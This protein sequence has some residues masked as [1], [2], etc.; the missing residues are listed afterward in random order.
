[1][2]LFTRYGFFSVVC[3]TESY[4]FVDSRELTGVQEERVAIRARWRNHL[5]A[6]QRR[7]PELSGSE[8]QITEQRDY[9]YRIL[10]AKK[11]W[12][13]MVAELAAE[14][15]WSNFKSEVAVFQGPQGSG[16][17][18]VLHQVWAVMR[19]FQDQESLPD[20]PTAASPER[21][22]A[23]TWN[24]GTP[25][26]LEDSAGQRLADAARDC[27]WRVVFE[28]LKKHPDRINATRPG[29]RSLYAPLHQAASCGAELEIVNRLIDLGAWRCLR[30]ASG[31]RPLEIAMRKGNVKIIDALT[32]VYRREVPSE[33]VEM[34][35]KRLHA[36]IQDVSGAVLSNQR[37]RLPELEPM[38][39]SGDKHFWFPVPGMH[40]GFHYWL[41][42]EGPTARLAVQSWSRVVAGSGLQFDITTERTTLVDQGFV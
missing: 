39:E 14:E 30:N 31:E 27:D 6:L 1:M 23:A 40:G 16:Y 8:I 15:T 5:E 28:I 12:S 11:L 22:P 3:P 21:A 41:I 34:L 38:L 19:E 4:G 25:H 10:A 24:G 17:T 20:S 2:W 36:L 29:G 32:P 35:Q 33:S 26:G 37:L 18:E 13:S 7:F 42:G 9:K